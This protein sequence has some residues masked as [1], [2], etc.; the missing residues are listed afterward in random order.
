[1]GPVLARL[2]DQLA[3]EGHALAQAF[4]D[5]VVESLKAG[6]GGGEGGGVAERLGAALP[7]LKALA[8][9]SG[10]SDDA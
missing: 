5:D 8:G 3:P 4:L 7:G 10:G 2:K 9:V 1:M 6:A